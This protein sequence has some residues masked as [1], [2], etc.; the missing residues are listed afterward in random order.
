M[1]YLYIHA[2]NREYILSSKN[3]SQVNDVR[4]TSGQ[5]YDGPEHRAQNESIDIFGL[6]VLICKF[7]FSTILQMHCILS[8]F[9]VKTVTMRFNQSLF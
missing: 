3:V 8:I 6:V 7:M 2:R 4:S 1:I 5:K 9:D